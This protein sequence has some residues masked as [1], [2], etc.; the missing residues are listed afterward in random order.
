M[1]ITYQDTLSESKKRFEDLFNLFEQQLN[2]KRDQP[3]HQFR[4]AAMD[5]FREPESPPRRTEDWK[6]TPVSRI[7]QLPLLEGAS[8]SAS[9]SALDAVSI[10]E[11]LKIVLI[12]GELQGP[13]PAL[14]E[15]LTILPVETAIRDERFA[16]WITA[17][18]E[19]ALAGAAHPFTPLNL[20]FA[21]NGLFI[22]AADNA[23]IEKPVQVIMVNGGGDPAFVNPQI[24]VKAGRNSQLQLIESYAGEGESASFT[25]ALNR[26]YLGANARVIHYKWQQEG[27][28][29]FQIH[30]TEVRQERDSV[31]TAYTLDLGGRLVRNN[32]DAIHLGQGVHTD[33]YG[34]YIVNGEQHIDNHTFLDHALPNCTSNELYKGIITDKGTGVFNGKV[35]VRQDAQK[36]NAFQQN[37]TLVLSP[38]ATMDSKPQLEIFADDVRCSHGA[39]IGQLDESAVFYLRS[40][41]LNKDQARALLQHA[42]VMEALET[43]PLETLKDRFEETIVQKLIKV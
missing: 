1:N 43:I 25:N 9:K 16:P 2:G 22:H 24:L 35:I 31:Y 21:R 8:F 33:F 38:T 30:Q 10:P 11:A 23:A 13:I 3:L 15:G 39:T 28:E 34:V 5:K 17:T 20:A 29:N 27:S 26:F 32:L 37:S 4:L 6:Y 36:T 18:L 40:R 42:F 12:N 7:L 19:G 14:P 41:G